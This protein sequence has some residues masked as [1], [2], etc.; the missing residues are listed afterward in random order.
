MKYGVQLYS[1]RNMIESKGLE[2]A[3]KT[4]AVSGYQGV[5][6]AGFYNYSPYEIKAM[7]EKYGLTAVSAHI[8]AEDVEDFFEYVRVLNIK[9]VYTAGILDECWLEE[10][11]SETVRKHKKAV[12]FLN[13]KGVGFGYHNHS[14]EYKDGNDLVKK[15]TDDV[16]GMRIELDICWITYAGKNVVDM[17]RAYC[18]KLETIHIKELAEGNPDCPPPIV[19]EG[20]VDMQGALKEAK[21]QGI[22]WGILEVENFDMPE[23][24]YL[25]KS[26]ENI[27][28]IEKFI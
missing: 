8:Q 15:I 28:K 24:E 18:D 25:S 26:L 11:Y 17:M 22:E 7:L 23:R 19:G 9:N 12:D 1:L 6:F 16:L 2:E 21:R 4:V 13:E 10:N 27:R 20:I 14:Y 5:E 3:I